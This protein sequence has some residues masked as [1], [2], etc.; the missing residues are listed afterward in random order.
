MDGVELP[1]GSIIKVEPADSAYKRNADSF[2]ASKADQNGHRFS[3]EHQVNYP[4][5]EVLG[6]QRDDDA[7]AADTVDDDLDDFFNSL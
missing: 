6:I 3:N 1:C 7:G 2:S 5:S 4:R